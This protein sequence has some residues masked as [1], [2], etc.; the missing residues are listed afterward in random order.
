MIAEWALD[1][2]LWLLCAMLAI[3]TQG[4]A[5]H[6]SAVVLYIVFGLVMALIWAR[7]GAF[8]LA[9]AEA[10][11]GAG[12]TGFLLL[13]ALRHH[14]PYPN[15]SRRYWM[16]CA[17][18]I[19]SFLWLSVSLSP[20]YSGIEY[21][22]PEL[23]QSVLDSGVSHPVTAVLLNIRALDTLL[24][25]MVLAV[26]VTSLGLLHPMPLN[27]AQPWP[28]LKHWSRLLV[29]LVVLVGG[30]VLWRGSSGPG[31]AFQAGAILASGLILLHLSH[32][33]PAPSWH[34]LWSRLLLWLAV[35]IF[36]GVGLASLGLG[37]PL[38]AIPPTQ[39]YAV[40]MLIELV[41]TLSIA[42]A[43]TIAVIGWREPVA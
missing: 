36:T 38:L 30:Y 22:H 29:P 18:P 5:N 20:W 12:L 23:S 21:P 2:S 15:P 4:V 1:L 39:S 11:I 24:E 26:A 28:L 37:L 32:L 19:V 9:I 27:S 7:L 43:L 33:L 41:A 8:D 40:L 34:S 10:A 3:G 16:F 25:L 31:G 42:I 17:L 13:Q 6:R 35:F 14:R